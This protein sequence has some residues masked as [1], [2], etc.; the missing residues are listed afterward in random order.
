MSW[1]RRRVLRGAVGGL[2]VALALPA[3]EATLPA[4]HAADGGLGPIFGLF[5]WANGLPWHAGHGALQA[6]AGNLDLWTP[7][8]TGTGF[9]APPLLAPIAH[10]DISVLTGLTPWTDIPDDPAGQGDG[11]MRGFMVA[12]T[13]DRPR[14]EGFD[15]PTHT[16]TALRPSLDQLVARDPGFYGDRPC[17]YRSLELGTSVARFHDYGHWNNISHS[18][19][20]AINPAITDPGRLYDMIFGVPTGDAELERRSVL[21]DAVLEDAARLRA[22]LGAADAARLSDH[23][24]HLYEVQRRLELGALACEAPG[25]APASSTDLLTQT[26]IQSELLALGLACNITRVFSFMLSSPASTHV[27]GELGIRSGMHTVCHEGEWEQVRDI[28]ALQMQCFAVLLDRLAETTDPTG[29]SL[30]D[31][32][33]VY[34][35]SEYGEGYQHS[36]A[37]MPVVIAGRANGALV[38]GHHLREAGGNISRA[39]L[40]LLQALGLDLPQFGFHGGETREA[41]TELLA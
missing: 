2:P 36:V 21:L 23:M 18:G 10:R 20:D 39:Q 31:R 7:T 1:S 9:A 40:T 29:A 25:A 5:F 11:H 37:E 27:F 19:P 22:Q 8:S 32:A 38:P 28:T 4:A 15:H 24:E 41:F 26:A 12:L 35:V 6:G 13:G 34:G 30:L 17:R 33:A 3:L 14:S 16:L